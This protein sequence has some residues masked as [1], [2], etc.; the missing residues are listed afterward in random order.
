MIEQLNS[1][2]YSKLYKE[3][4]VANHVKTEK[5]NY[6]TDGVL[7]TELIAEFVLQKI[8]ENSDFKLAKTDENATYSSG[9]RK[10]DKG[11]VSTEISYL[12]KYIYKKSTGKDGKSKQ[13][14]EDKAVH[15]FQ[16][17]QKIGEYNFVDYQVPTSKGR[18]DK[19]DLLIERNGTLFVVEYKKMPI[20]SK[21]DES[22][23]DEI[24]NGSHSKETLLR[25]VLEIK[26]YFDKLNNQFYKKYQ[27]T[28][29]N[30][31]M[32]VMFDKHSQAHKELCDKEKNKNVISLMKIWGIT[33]LEVVVSQ[34]GFEI[35][36]IV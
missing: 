7:I 21:Y 33:P 30:V 20:F 9:G 19:I 12:L 25:C 23:F 1:F 11:I 8:A 35:K 14:I 5:S 28:A 18:G 36:E 10:Y 32:A 22:N 15:C 17:L 16:K 3:S 31:K 4:I 2:N 24:E 34:N 13:K 26:T 29:E 27:T 6:S